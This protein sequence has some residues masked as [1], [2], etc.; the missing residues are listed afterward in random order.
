[1]VGELRAEGLTDYVAWPLE[2]TLGKRHV[3]TFA[4]D[5]PGGFGDDHMAV[6][7][8]LLPALALVSEIRLK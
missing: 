2:H 6:L 7:A 4:T 1:M 5:R 3:V 8:D